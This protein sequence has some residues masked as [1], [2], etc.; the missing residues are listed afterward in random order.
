[1]WYQN[2]LSGNGSTST[3]S[4]PIIAVNARQMNPDNSGKFTN[5]VNGYTNTSGIEVMADLLYKVKLMELM[6]LLIYHGNNSW[7]LMTVC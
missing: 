2:Q 6:L 4:V 1:M 5:N 7:V 3:W